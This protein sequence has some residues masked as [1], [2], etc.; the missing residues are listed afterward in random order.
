M[1]SLIFN[2]SLYSNI[3]PLWNWNNPDPDPNPNLAA[4]N[5]NKLLETT[6][7][8]WLI[9]ITC[10]TCAWLAIGNKI[11]KWSRFSVRILLLYK[12]WNIY[13]GLKKTLVSRKHIALRSKYD[14]D[15]WRLSFIFQCFTGFRF[16]EMYWWRWVFATCQEKV[17]SKYCLNRVV[18]M[19]PSL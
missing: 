13:V 4:D 11:S 18:V 6:Q 7:P 19:L 12:A 5:H 16:S 8:Y 14:I 2:L 10:G 3:Q 9:T 17:L 15:R 1:D